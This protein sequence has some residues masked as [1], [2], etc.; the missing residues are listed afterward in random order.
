MAENILFRNKNICACI[1][2]CVYKFS[3]KNKKIIM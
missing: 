1:M 2:L 3:R